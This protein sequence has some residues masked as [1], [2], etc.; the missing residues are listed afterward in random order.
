MKSCHLVGIAG[1]GMNALAQALKGGGWV[2]SGSDRYEDQ[3][4]DLEVIRKLKEGGI[5][6]CP[7]DGSGI[8]P[9]TGAVVVSTAIEQDNTDVVAAQRFGVPVRH[10]AEMLAELVQGK[11]TVAIAG[12]SGKTT[13]TGMVGW[14]LEQLGADP[15]VVNGGALVNWADDHHVGNVRTGGSGLC[16]IEVDES[17]R[18]LLRFSPD[19]ALITNMSADHFSLEETVGLFSQFRSQVRRDCMAGWDPGMPWQ[20]LKPVL[21]RT[22]C[23]FAYGGLEFEISL[24]GAHNAENALQ[25]VVL[26]HRMGF[27]LGRIRDALAQFKGIQRRLERVGEAGGVTVVDEYAHNPAK[28]SAAWRAVAPYYSRVTAFWRPHGFK[29]LSMMFNDLVA[30][31]GEVCRPGDRLF[32][33][34]VYYAG[35]TVSKAMDSDVLAT[36]LQARGVPAVWVPDYDRLM[37]GIMKDCQSGEVVL[38]VGARDP[39]IPRFARELVNRLG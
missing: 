34:P 35:G 7:Q 14:L 36:A 28:I 15:T 18:S 37:S 23:R 1:V 39:G 8:S 12:T 19:R 6:F 11:E 31:F 25:A 24:L 3:G 30:M 29:P 26:C 17:D 2:V 38:C 32:L 33:M 27:D 5:R 9:E 10:R 13:V 22:G 21:S 16:V 20:G 4:Q